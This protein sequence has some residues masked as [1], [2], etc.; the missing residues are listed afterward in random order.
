MPSIALNLYPLPILPVVK[1]KIIKKPFF[2]IAEILN[3]RCA[4]MGF[5]IAAVKGIVSHKIVSEQLFDNSPN[6]AAFMEMSI[7]IGLISAGTCIPILLEKDV[8]RSIGPFTKEAELKNGRLAMVAMF[9][10]FLI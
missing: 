4:M 7:L 5:D 1:P 2:E 6:Y 3:G 10:L 8:S 9:I